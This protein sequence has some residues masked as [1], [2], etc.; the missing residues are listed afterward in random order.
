MCIRDRCLVTS[1]NTLNKLLDQFKIGLLNMARVDAFVN[2][3][4]ATTGHSAAVAPASHTDGMDASGTSIVST[5]QGIVKRATPKITVKDIKR[6]RRKRQIDNNNPNSKISCVAECNVENWNPEDFNSN[7]SASK[8]A[9]QPEPQGGQDNININTDSDCE[10]TAWIFNLVI[11]P[12]GSVRVESDDFQY[13]WDLK[14]NNNDLKSKSDSTAQAIKEFEKWQ[15]DY[16][17]QVN[18]NPTCNFSTIDMQPPPL[19]KGCPSDIGKTDRHQI[20]WVKSLASGKFGK[21]SCT[22][23]VE[24]FDPLPSDEPLHIRLKPGSTVPTMHRHR[25]PDHLLVLI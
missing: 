23:P 10:E 20:E 3:S 6:A 5:S 18:Y 24:K 16:F 17:K 11:T 13:E 25:C 12:K 8:E 15:K 14:G 19:Y 7:S 9:A 1:T 4:Q 21:F 2:P 22:D